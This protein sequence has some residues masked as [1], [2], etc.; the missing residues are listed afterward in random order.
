MIIALLVLLIL[1]YL[2]FSLFAAHEMT[3]RQAPRLDVTPE[4]VSENYEDIE[5]KSTDNLILRGWL[6][7]A[8]SDKLIIMI[9]GLTQN[10]INTAYYAMWVAKDFVDQDYN[11]IM[12]DPRA[13]GKSE[14]NRLSYGRFEGNDV[15]GATKFAKERGFTPE[16]IAII[17]DSTG[18]ITTLMIADQ[19]N[20]IGALII[21]SAATNFKPF[22]I[23]RLWTEKNVP[24]FFSPAVFFFTDTV[25]GTKIGE[26]K[27]IEKLSLVPERKFLY[28]HGELDD[29]FPVEE[30]KKLLEASNPESKLIIFPKGNHVETFKSDPELYRKEVLS[31]L[32]SELGR[33]P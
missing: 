21:D 9:P 27:P 8:N 18:A 7:K 12:Y 1:F 13:N 22:I 3:K 6:F 20:E 14:G 11:V 33:L 31:F 29:L 19:L 17:G 23:K 5:F 16:N 32:S 28:L 15:L 10:R 26:V 30:S 24:T 25:F 2:G 4:L